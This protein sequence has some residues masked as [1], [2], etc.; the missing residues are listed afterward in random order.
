MTFINSHSYKCLLGPQAKNI[1]EQSEIYTWQVGQKQHLTTSRPLTTS[2]LPLLNSICPSNFHY[3]SESNVNFLKEHFQVKRVKNLSIIIDINNLTF[4]GNQFKSIRHCLNKCSKNDLMLESNFRSLDDIKK[5]INEWSELYT[6]KYFRDFSG[7][8]LFFYKNDFHRDCL[9]LFAY[10][11]INLVG[12]GTLTPNINGES[13]Y[14]IG[15]ALYKRIYGL[16]EWLDV[17][18]YQRAQTLGIKKVNLGQASKGLLSYKSQFSH[19]EE[20]HFDGNLAI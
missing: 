4:S 10:Q 5:L 14:V 12:F 2:D 9:N 1:L 16:S 15:K 18:L 11:G 6:D 17:Q 3:F 8:N 13:S 19:T 7:K 20:R